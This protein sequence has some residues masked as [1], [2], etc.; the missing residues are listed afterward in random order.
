MGLESHWEAHCDKC[1]S[2]T[3]LPGREG[4]PAKIAKNM[5]W[6]KF[7]TKWMCPSCHKNTRVAQKVDQLAQEGE[8]P[9]RIE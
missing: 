2:W 8:E 6:R 5:G 9:W 7:G 4:T 1:A 3:W